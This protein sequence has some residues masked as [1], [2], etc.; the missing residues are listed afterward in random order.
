MLIDLAS[1]PMSIDMR[2]KPTLAGFAY[3]GTRRDALFWG[4]EWTDA[5]VMSILET[6]PR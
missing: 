6:D 5:I 3:E 1:A 4:G 2:T